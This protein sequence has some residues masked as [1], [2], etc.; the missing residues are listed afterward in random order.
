MSRNL[1]QI[2]TNKL[3]DLQINNIYCQ[4]ETDGVSVSEG[5]G[6]K[7]ISPPLSPSEKGSGGNKGFFFDLYSPQI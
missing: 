3:R 7:L 6:S 4:Q 1:S 2:N 5:I